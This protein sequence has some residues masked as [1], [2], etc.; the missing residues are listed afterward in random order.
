[1][2]VGVRVL[3]EFEET[4]VNNIGSSQCCLRWRRTREHT[5]L[6]GS[7]QERMRWEKD[8]LT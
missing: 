8:Y 4:R 3:S 2:H 6:V 1:M 7:D 5:V